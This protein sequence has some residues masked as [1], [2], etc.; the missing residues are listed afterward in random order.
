MKKA[1]IFILV[2]LLVVFSFFSYKWIKHRMEYAITDAVF[3]KSENLGNVAFEVSGRVVEVY[4]DLGDYVKKGEPLAKIEDTD[5]KLQVENL[6]AR[7]RSL[8]AQ[9]EALS[10]QIQKASSQTDLNV[11]AQ[12][13]TLKELQAKEKALLSQL[14][15]LEVR[16]NQVRKDR[17]RLENLLKEGLIPSQKFEQIDTEYKSLLKRRQALEEN[18]EEIRAGYQ[19]AQ[20]SLQMAEAEI[21]SVSEL[22][23]RLEALQSEIESVRRMLEKAQLDLE[24]T[25]LKS[26]L[27]GLIAK[28]FI[29]VGDM[30]RSGQPAFSVVATNSLYV[31]ALLEET[32]LKGVKV[33]SKAYF[34]PDAFPDKVFEGVVEEISPASAATFALMPRDI[35]AGE[36]TK[37]VQRIPV[38]VRLLKGDLSLLRVGMGGRLEIKR[39]R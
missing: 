20:K 32:K 27:E 4:K 26:P 25:I 18:I 15:E 16:L 38:K 22:R 5:Y 33:G 17:Q 19:K 37:V 8:E 12:Q 36:F 29:S 24:R 7:L 10:L 11:K 35:S 3:V 9:K 30:V 6:Q 39:E 2:C 31:E 21:L 28:R 23:K 34:Y 1:G 14:E 13:D